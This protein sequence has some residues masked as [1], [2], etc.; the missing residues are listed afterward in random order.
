VLHLLGCSMDLEDE[1][2]DFVLNEVIDSLY[3]DGEE[4]FY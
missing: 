2:N 1:F 4:N 3:S